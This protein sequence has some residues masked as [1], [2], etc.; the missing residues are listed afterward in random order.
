[1]LICR[2]SSASHH[3]WMLSY[4]PPISMAAMLTTDFSDSP[5]SAYIAQ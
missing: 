5:R 1:M 3:N 2:Q 4:S